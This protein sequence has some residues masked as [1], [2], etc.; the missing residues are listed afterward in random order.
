MK[1]LWCPKH[2]DV[3]RNKMGE[4]NVNQTGAAVPRPRETLGM[5]LAGRFSRDPGANRNK[6]LDCPQNPAHLTHSSFA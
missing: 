5:G 6:H 1:K 3:A 4:S 2:R